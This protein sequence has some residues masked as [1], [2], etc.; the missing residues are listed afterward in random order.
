M[1]LN[2]TKTMRKIAFA[3]I[4][5]LALSMNASAAG[6]LSDPNNN[7]ICADDTGCS[8][9]NRYSNDVCATSSF[10]YTYSGTCNKLVGGSCTSGTYTACPNDQ[11]NCY[12]YACAN[13]QIVTNAGCY[14]LGGG[15]SCV[16]A[17][18]A[19]GQQSNPCR[20]AQNHACQT[21]TNGQTG[22]AQGQCGQGQACYNGACV[23]CT[24]P[25]PGGN[26]KGGGGCCSGTFNGT[27]GWTNGTGSFC[28][29]CAGCLVNG[30]CY[31]DGAPIAGNACTVCS[32]GQSITQATN[33]ASGTA[34]G[35]N[36][37]AGCAP[38]TRTCN[39][40][41]V[42]Q[43]CTPSQCAAASNQLL[44]NCPPT[45]V[46]NTTQILV[47]LYVNGAAACTQ[48]VSLSI[49]RDG[50]SAGSSSLNPPCNPLP[51]TFNFSVNTQTNGTY[52]ITATSTGAQAVTCSFIRTA[53][54]PTFRVPDSNPFVAILAGLAA[55]L[56]LLGR[57][58]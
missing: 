10:E 55:G 26:P 40:A 33:A 14:A 39:N 51:N 41:G 20:Y 8:G 3:M 32:T 5:L 50:Q 15:P 19:I 38:C 13:D 4:A 43:T 53:G 21:V 49:S 28:I 52:T 9:A 46:T 58:R 57:K 34:C 35:T 6:T 16:N 27:A 25:T 42:C 45:S 36:T 18:Q 12:K 17:C 30:V 23:S 11:S 29:D 7:R 56:F 48:G 24:P 31:A 22:G 2:N 1:I 47:Q 37:A 44:I 54:R